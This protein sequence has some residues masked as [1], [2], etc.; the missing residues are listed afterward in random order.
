MVNLVTQPTICCRLAYALSCRYFLNDVLTE[1]MRRD[2]DSTARLVCGA[3]AIAA[4]TFW[5]S[6]QSVAEPIRVATLN[7]PPSPAE[8]S[9]EDSPPAVLSDSD[10]D[11]YAHIF[12]LQSDGKWREADRAIAKLNNPILMGHVQFQRYMHPT[13]YRANYTELKNWLDLYGDHPGADRAYRLA[14]RR[15]PG[16]YKAPKRPSMP[17]TSMG[18]A[19]APT[20]ESY[21]SD[22]QRSKGA[23]REIDRIQQYVRAN[24][25]QDRIS[26]SE[27]YLARTSVR[28]L[29]D[30]VEIDELNGKIAAAR[31]YYGQYD[32]AYDL[33]AKAADRSR[34]YLNNPDWIAGLSAWRANRPAVARQHFEAIARSAVA[35]PWMRAAGAFWAARANLVSERPEKVNELLKIAA[36]Y[37]RTFYGLIAARQLGTEPDFDWA[38]PPLSNLGYERLINIPG[39]QRAVALAQSGE[40]R[41]ADLELR[42]IYLTASEKLGEP[43]LALA[44]RLDLPA[45]QLR[46]A[47]GIRSSDDRPYDRALFPLPPWRPADGF[48]VDQALL[49]AFMRQE[50]GFNTKAKSSVGARGLMQLMPRTASFVAQDRSLR[51]S[52]RSKLFDPEFNLELGQRYVGH[53]LDH[54]LINGDLF[55]LAVAYNAGPGNLKKWLRNTPT[56]DPLLFI[57]SIPS[58]E[59]RIFVER[60]LTNFWVY[61]ERLNQDTPSLDAVAT[62]NSPIYL[63]LDGASLRLAANDRH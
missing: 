23:W 48:A 26:V 47:R 62:G 61:R 15:Q 40:H 8:L 28:R 49:F 58:R 45:I 21:R 52:N 32:E 9:A 7:V 3:L 36:S 37:P 30:P 27:K 42:R 22:R 63:A 5:A 41:L 24:L 20:T 56:D 39:V 60:V 44:H 54:E 43:L 53:L 25:R 59:T 4:V 33:A 34:K 11:L 19:D 50:S 57:E 46:L 10:A 6:A 29:L 55:R 35:S 17:R 12:N 31:Y 16:G 38:P 18:Y 51:R 1:A 14:L 13:R 2:A